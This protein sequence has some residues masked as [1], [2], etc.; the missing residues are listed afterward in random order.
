MI[1]SSMSDSKQGN[2]LTP[3]SPQKQDMVLPQEPRVFLYKTFTSL[4]NEVMSTKKVIEELKGE[5][6]YGKQK[7]NKL[8]Y[9][10]FLLHQKGFPVNEIYDDKLKDIPTARFMEFVEQIELEQQKEQD[11]PHDE[12]G[13]PIPP[14]D[15]PFDT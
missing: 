7:E 15:I 9:L 5:V 3:P 6:F 2:P 1:D 13:Q 4:V 11:L 10:F 8:M 12:D 14:S